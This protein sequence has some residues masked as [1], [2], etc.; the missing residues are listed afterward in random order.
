VWMFVATSLLLK[1]L[2]QHPVDFASFTLSISLYY[3]SFLFKRTN[4]CCS[5]FIN[6]LDLRIY[7]IKFPKHDSFL[8]F[9]F[10]SVASL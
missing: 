5:V 10:I 2:E 9:H 6:R 1:P 8:F 7:E 4:N 3:R